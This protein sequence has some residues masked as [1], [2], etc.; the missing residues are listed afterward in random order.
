MTTTALDTLRDEAEREQLLADI[1]EAQSRRRLLEAATSWN[2]HAIDPSDAYRDADGTLWEPVHTTG[3]ATDNSLPFRNLQE[4]HWIRQ[5]CRRLT[6]E[7]EFALS[8]HENRV[9]YLIGAGHRYTCL[10]RDGQPL[11][12]SLRKRIERLIA[13]FCERQHWSSRQQEILWRTDRDGE[14]FLRFFPASV[15]DGLLAVRFIEPE[16]VATPSSRDSQPHAAWGVLTEPHDHETVLGY[17]V[18]DVFLAADEVQHRKANVDGS[19]RRG[20]PLFYP[21][22]GNLDRCE[23]LLRNMS[24][25]AQTQAAIAVVRRHRQGTAASVQAFADAQA[26]RRSLD[27]SS[28]QTRRQKRLLPGTILDAPAGVEYDFPAAGINAAGL[29][30]VLQAELRAVA[31]RLVMPEFMLTADANRAHYASTLA[32]EGPA[33]KTFRRWQARIIADD[34]QVFDRLLDRAVEAGL[35]SQN[36]RQSVAIHA[37][38]PTVAVRDAKQDAETNAIKLAAGVKSRTTWQLEDGLDP[39]REQAHFHEEQSHTRSLGS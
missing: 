25:L 18:D 5:R 1:A 26:T 11:G 24:I 28:G 2:D 14:C 32:A 36:E 30:D 19:S 13:T 17:F 39:M 31:A 20:I 3:N 4:L 10:S 15:E 23:R 27:P 12:D 6:L 29:V 16:Q 35:I 34:L 8:G 22:L 7:N 38:P 33:V 9:S 21:V 37:E